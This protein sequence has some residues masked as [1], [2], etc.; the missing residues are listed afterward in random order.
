MSFSIQNYHLMDL[1]QGRRKQYLDF[2]NYKNTFYANNPYC[3]IELSKE[4][5][6]YVPYIDVFYDSVYV[7]TTY[8]FEDLLQNTVESSV[9]TIAISNKIANTQKE[10]EHEIDIQNRLFKKQ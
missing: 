1:Y 3:E 9:Y 10:I 8:D 4:R 2:L 5:G 6:R 7:R